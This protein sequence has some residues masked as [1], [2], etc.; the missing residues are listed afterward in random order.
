MPKGHKTE[1]FYNCLNVED[2][3]FTLCGVQDHFGKKQC[4][5]L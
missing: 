2:D 1:A 3:N 5:L 4:R